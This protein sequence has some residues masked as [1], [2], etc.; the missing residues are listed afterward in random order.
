MRDIWST[1]PLNKVPLCILIDMTMFV[2]LWM[3]YL[4]TVVGISKTYFP[5]TIM[6]DCTLDYSKH[7]RVEFGIYIETHKD[8]PTTNIMAEISQGYI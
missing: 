6:K 7:Y 1:L 3:N 5:R 8:E 2:V 4:T